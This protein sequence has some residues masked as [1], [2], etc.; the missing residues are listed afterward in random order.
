MR[1]LLATG[2]L[3][4]TAATSAPSPYLLH[5]G[6]CSVI[7]Y[8]NYPAPI[9]NCTIGPSRILH[10]GSIAPANG[11]ESRTASPATVMRSTKAERGG[12]L[13]PRPHNV[14][15]RSL[16]LLLW[17]NVFYPTPRTIT[18]RRYFSSVPF[19]ATP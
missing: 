3:L 10:S 6:A 2:T 9:Y 15:C 11:T 17:G 14:R 5:R 8:Y 19:P 12:C 13:R 16:L 4:T 1:S 7:I 18:A